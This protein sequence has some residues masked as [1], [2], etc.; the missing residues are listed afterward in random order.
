MNEQRISRPANFH[1]PLI[2]LSLPP[3]L[4]RGAF[5]LCQQ[6]LVVVGGRCGLEHG[7]AEGVLGAVAVFE[8][9]V[10]GVDLHLVQPRVWRCRRRGSPLWALWVDGSH[11]IWPGAVLDGRCEGQRRAQ[12]VFGPQGQQAGVLAGHVGGHG[13]SGGLCSV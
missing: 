2:Q 6:T 10:E 12:G 3:R 11:A 5:D 8:E 1:F 4:A 13:E 9:G 7:G